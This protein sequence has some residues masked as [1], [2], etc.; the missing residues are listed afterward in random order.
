MNVCRVEQGLV[1]IREHII[2]RL[3]GD[4][5]KHRFWKFENYETTVCPPYFDS[6]INNQ[7]II[8]DGITYMVD[9]INYLLT[10]DGTFR[11]VIPSARLIASDFDG[12]AVKVVSPVEVINSDNSLPLREEDILFIWQ[13]SKVY[14]RY[15]DF[16]M[17]SEAIYTM[18][19]LKII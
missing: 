6:R 18:H 1:S 5:A 17:F 19:M 15:P 16:I 14:T 3:M 8:F 11:R 9:S 13:P 2:S 7:Q 4:K 12:K 10:E